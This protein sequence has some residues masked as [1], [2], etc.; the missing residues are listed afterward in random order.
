MRD[1]AANLREQFKEPKPQRLGL[2]STVRS[3]S[4]TSGKGGVGKTNIVINMAIQLSKMGKK[5]LILDADLGLANIDIMLNLV[6]EFTIEDVLMGK[7]GINE[8]IQHGPEGVHVLPASSGITEMSELNSDQ[9]MSLIK[10]LSR[11][12]DNYDYILIDTGAGIAS[13]VLRFN[14]AADEIC[15][16][17]N[18]EPTAMTDAYALMKIMATKYQVKRFNL[19]INQATGMAEAKQVHQKLATV[20]NQFLPV[21][22]VLTGFIPKD[23]NFSKAVR[24]QSPLSVMFPNS[25]T[26]KAFYLLAKHIDLNI[27]KAFDSDRPNFFQRLGLWKRK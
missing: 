3:L 15:V 6:P 20:F 25:P 4:F 11:L 9:Q 7:K 13:S 22:L 23:P 14:A 12:K 27:G 10:E 26:A 5:V 19:I 1:Q 18:T 24:N 21:D 8:V 2:D 17:T 16:V